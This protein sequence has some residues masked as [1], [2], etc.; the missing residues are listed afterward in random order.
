PPSAI[1]TRAPARAAARAAPSPAGPAPSTS[2]SW[3]TGPDYLGPGGPPG[4][5]RTGRPAPV[6]PRSLG[7]ARPR[8]PVRARGCRPA[9]RGA[10]DADPAER[11]GRGGD[12]AG[13]R[14]RAPLGAPADR[15]PRRARR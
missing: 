1:A 10:P 7:Y 11:V 15:L 4:R 14:A 13:R 5:G 9:G 8:G 6:L 3:G 2:R 12:G